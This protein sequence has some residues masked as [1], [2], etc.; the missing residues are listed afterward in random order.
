M[1]FFLAD[2]LWLIDRSK[3]PGD[4][5]RR[6]LRGPDK[7]VLEIMI[8]FSRVDIKVLFDTIDHRKTSATRGCP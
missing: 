2:I 4:A 6:V 3:R 8:G 7:G 1:F 5:R